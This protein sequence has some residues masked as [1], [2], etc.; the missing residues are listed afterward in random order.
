M[1]DIVVGESVEEVIETTVSHGFPV[2]DTQLVRWHR[3]G[4]L[5]PIGKEIPRLF[6]GRTGRGSETIYPPGTG[7]Q[8]AALRRA[9][10]EK[11]DLSRAGWVLWWQGYEVAPAYVYDPLARVLKELETLVAFARANGG[12]SDNL[13]NGMTKRPTPLVGAM[14]R[15]L[16]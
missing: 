9:L 2:S 3:E 12:L 5:P 10:K 16:G 1:S 6:P 14:R 11:R 4:L 8:A 13:I 7:A 15:R